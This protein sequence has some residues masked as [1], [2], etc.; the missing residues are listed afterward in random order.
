LQSNLG[1]TALMVAAGQGQVACVQALLQAKANTELIDN[2]GYTALQRA[3]I[4][5]HTATAELIRQHA[6]PLQPAAASPAAPPDAGEPAVSSPT[7]LP[8][9]AYESAGRGELRKGGQV[10][11]QGRADRRALFQMVT[12]RP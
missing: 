11:V 12:V 6:A 10:A 9:E 2:H 7:S 5:G 1:T 4:N 3:K 8:V